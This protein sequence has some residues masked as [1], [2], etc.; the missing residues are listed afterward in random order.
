M[1]HA[2]VSEEQRMELGITDTLIRMSVG[3][4]D[5]QD[6]IA[7]LD[8]ALSAAI[9]VYHVYLR[10]DDVSLVAAAADGLLYSTSAD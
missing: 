3:L 5:E 1:T 7:D 4:E 9:C 10:M 8:Q 6:I 2:S